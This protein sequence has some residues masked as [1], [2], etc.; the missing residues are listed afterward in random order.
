MAERAL[1][2]LHRFY[3][4]A[5]DVDFE[6]TTSTRRPREHKG[7]AATARVCSDWTGNIVRAEQL[8]P[9]SGYFKGYVKAKVRDAPAQQG[10]S[11]RLTL[12]LGPLGPPNADG[13]ASGRPVEKLRLS[14]TPKMFEVVNID[15]NRLLTMNTPL[16]SCPG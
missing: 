2:R 1:T 5:Y 13:S 7:D 4:S 8:S 11:V 3:A 14:T 10:R 9:G 6:W 12:E 15:D 16:P